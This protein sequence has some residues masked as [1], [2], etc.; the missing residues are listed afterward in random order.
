MAATNKTLNRI[1]RKVRKDT[2]LTEDQRQQEL[3]LIKQIRKG[4]KTG[5]IEFNQS[6]IETIRQAAEKVQ[7]KKNMNLR[8]KTQASSRKAKRAAAEETRGAAIA[9]E[10]GTDAFDYQIMGSTDSDA[11]SVAQVEGIEDAYNSTVSFDSEWN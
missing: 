2:T 10:L 1:A 8:S 5:E 11:R 9:P 6:R 7:S 4:L 3:A